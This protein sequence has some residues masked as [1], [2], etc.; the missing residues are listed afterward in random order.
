MKSKILVNNTDPNISEDSI[1]TVV[2]LRENGIA[3][4]T[5]TANNTEGKLYL[6]TLNLYD[7]VIIRYEYSED[8]LTDEEWL[9]IDPV[10]TGKIIELNNSLVREGETLNII[11]MGKGYCS[12]LMRV[13]QEYGQDSSLVKWLKPS[14]PATWEEFIYKESTDE[15]VNISK[16]VNSHD[17]DST[18]P[19]QWTLIGVTPYLHDFDETNTILSNAMTTGNFGN[20]FSFQN[21]DIKYYAFEP[22]ANS[23]IEIYA[24]LNDG[25]GGHA[26][27]IRV[28]LRVWVE[29]STSWETLGWLDLTNVDWTAGRFFGIEEHWTTLEDW[30]NGKIKID[31]TSI[32]DG[33]SDKGG[34]D[35]TFAQFHAEGVGKYYKTEWCHV[36]VETGK[37]TTQINCP[38][39]QQVILHKACAE[40]KEIN[41]IIKIYYRWGDSDEWKQIGD[42]IGGDCYACRCPGD[43]DSN[44]PCGEPSNCSGGNTYV[45]GPTNAP[46]QVKWTLDPTNG[47]IGC[48]GNMRIYYNFTDTPEF[49][50]MKTLRQ[51]LTDIDFGLVPYFIEKILN[52]EA[53]SGYNLNTDYIY[54]DLLAYSYLNFPYQDAFMCLQ[55]LIRIGSSLHYIADLTGDKS[56]WRGLH[57]R[58]TPNGELLIAPVGNHNVPGIDE[59]HIV[60]K[61]WSTYVNNPLYT[62]NDTIIVKEDMIVQAFK[63]EVPLANYVLVAGKYVYPINDLWTES[64]S[65]WKED[66][67][68]LGGVVA[69][70]ITLSLDFNTYIKE[71]SSLKY[72]FD[73][74][75]GARVWG[76]IS[77][78]L[79][80]DFTKLIH[81]DSPV[82]ICLRIKG[83]MKGEKLKLRLYCNENAP[84][85]EY[86]GTTYQTR[87][88]WF[89]TDLQTHLIKDDW[90]PIEIQVTKEDLANVEAA[91]VWESHSYGTEY[92]E[93]T[94][95]G[96]KWF[97]IYYKSGQNTSYPL[98]ITDTWNID[99]IKIVGNCIRGAY[100]S[101][102]G[103]ASKEECKLGC[104]KH[105]DC[106][107]LTIRD[108]L[109]S[110]DNLNKDDDSGPLAELALYEL[111]RNRVI[112]TTGQI[113]IP[114]DNTILPGQ[115][116]HIHAAQNESGE[117]K[118]DEYFRIT[119]VLHTFTRMG[120]FTVLTLTN[121]LKNSIPINSIDPYTMVMRALNPDYQTRT[122]A[123]LKAGGIFFADQAPIS[124]DY[125]Y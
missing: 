112:R 21:L 46:L 58:T 59:S 86:D 90:N 104:I 87:G 93:P 23:Y 24:R 65:G 77:Q 31:V 6:A 50:K 5:L 43:T 13:A 15:N 37:Y 71:K 111:L 79:S 125:P 109:A 94:W 61:V 19:N 17:I 60:E 67:G 88:S 7:E 123:S 51:I 95:E 1:S 97:S 25:T 40:H 76:I 69:P 92:A 100:T 34:I 124:K 74:P 30:N 20:Y 68:H 48:I 117:Y 73:I 57:W 107:F 47:Y 63:T 39:N 80:S 83:Q 96:I 89:E 66:H 102:C 81:K 4:C 44:A 52:T 110:T 106:R 12:K 64:L 45:Y 32:T 42:E 55:D 35:V 75:H 27:S 122:Y 99:D 70:T 119:I 105:Y 26:T 9:A 121:D 91:E 56:M 72:K 14:E 54:N 101:D 98:G 118:I 41:G 28:Q 113:Q 120:A 10:F 33:G 84:T 53:S 108:S 16:I 114:L 29:H 8:E 49:Q 11:A 115:L 78:P 85:L 18:D 82:N 116:V 3:E 103:A 2:T 36:E 62:N 22:N 38:V